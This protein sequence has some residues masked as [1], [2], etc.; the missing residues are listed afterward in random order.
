MATTNQ[1]EICDEPVQKYLESSEAAYDYLEVAMLA[2]DP[3]SII[4]GVF[5]IADTLMWYTPIFLTC[6]LS[7]R[8]IMITLL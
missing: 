8:Y 4:E 6:E 1:L 5:R 2:Q 3:S 7:V